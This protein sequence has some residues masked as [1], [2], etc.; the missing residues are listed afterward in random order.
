MEF[1]STLPR[2]EWHLAIYSH[3][4]SCRFQSTLPRREWLCHNSDS[5]F[6]LFISIHTPKK[7]V[8]LSANIKKR[9]IRFQS[10]LPRREWHSLPL[11]SLPRL[12]FQST[13]PRREWRTTAFPSPG[14]NII[15]IH[16]PK[17]GVTRQC[18]PLLPLNMISIH[19]PKKGVTPTFKNISVFYWNFNP[20]SQEGSDTFKVAPSII[21]KVI[22]IHT[23]KKGVT[24][25]C[26]RCTRNSLFQSTL[27]RR[28]WLFQSAS[29]GIA[30]NFNPHSQEGSDWNFHVV[31]SSKVIS[32]HT[33]KKGV[34]SL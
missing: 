25:Q 5:P 30:G 11:L 27:P 19:T 8:T 7:G 23:P 24:F 2:R 3:L 20:H 6:L 4:L 1:Q 16:T 31:L 21:S 28:E 18:I 12:V 34:T 33:P 13:L 17:K 32:I 29:A 15:S 9:F 14:N 22:S 26:S 10:T